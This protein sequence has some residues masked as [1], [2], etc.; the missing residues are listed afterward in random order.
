MPDVTRLR[1]ALG[2]LGRWPEVV[3]CIRQAAGW[4][5]IVAAYAGARRLAL[6]AEVRLRD[7]NRFRLEE[8][9]DLD[10]L[11]QVYVREVYPVEPGDRCVI[12]AGANIGLFCC[13]AAR[14]A[15]GAEVHAVEPVPETFKRLEEHVHANGLAGRIHCVQAALA[16]RS[17]TVVMSGGGLPS[18]MARVVDNGAARGPDDG[19]RVPAIRLL[20][21]V[22]EHRARGVDLLKMDVEGSEYEVLL[23]TSAADLA[24]IRRLWLEYHEGL[25][26]RSTDK[27][28]LQQHL[29]AAGFHVVAEM[30]DGD[31]GIL[32]YARPR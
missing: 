8:F 6:P 23:S 24:P 14:R 11:W 2:H 9:Y 22:A 30:G 7:G 27:R 12:D 21:L 4:P 31:Y 17:G 29:T 1:A 19:V 25:G 15:P 18:Q 32:H 13:Y 10:T 26:A 28:R 20:D 5:T 3:N 16:S